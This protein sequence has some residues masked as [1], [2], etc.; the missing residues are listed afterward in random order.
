MIGVSFFLGI[1]KKNEKLSE[2]RSVVSSPHMHVLEN[3]SLVIAEVTSQDQGHYLCEA[4]NGVGPALS[5]VA[6][7]EVN[8]ECQQPTRCAQFEERTAFG[9]IWR[10]Y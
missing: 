1:G 10:T 2:F 7:L 3:G 9:T 4:S 6:Y 8:G 5:V